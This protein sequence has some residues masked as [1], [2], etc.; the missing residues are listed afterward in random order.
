M[1][2]MSLVTLFFGLAPAVAPI[3]GG[4]LFTGL[5][6]RAIFWFLA[7]LGLILIVTGARFLPET[8]AATHRQPFHPVALLKGYEEVGMGC[9]PVDRDAT[10]AA[11]NHSPRFY[12]DERALKLGVRTLSALALDWLSANAKG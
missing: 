7:A 9:T 5:G 3:I 1:T 4:W 12:V 8:L 10:T 6:W 2:C 11:P